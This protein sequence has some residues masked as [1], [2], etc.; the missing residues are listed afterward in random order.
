ML[1]WGQKKNIGE[2]L[3]AIIMFLWEDTLILWDLMAPIPLLFLLL[4]HFLWIIWLAHSEIHLLN[5]RHILRK[6]IG[7]VLKCSS[8]LRLGLLEFELLVICLL[9][10]HQILNVVVSLCLNFAAIAHISEGVI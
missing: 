7:D 4:Y 2:S 3:F 8:I 9:H 1:N 10:H 6:G 5:V